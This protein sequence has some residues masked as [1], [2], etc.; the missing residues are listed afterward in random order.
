MAGVGWVDYLWLGNT[1]IGIVRGGQLY[2]V[3]TDHLGRPEVV[4]N[5]ARA[6]VWRANN[7]AFGRDAVTI[8]T[9]GGLHIGFPGQ[10]HDVESGLEHNGM[11]AYDRMRGGYVQTDPIGQ[12][13][14]INTYAY[15]SGN[16]V[17]RIDPW[18]LKDYTACETW[19]ILD[20]AKR[21]MSAPLLQRTANASRNHGAFGKFDFKMNQ[22]ND[23]F[24]APL[25][26]RL[27]APEFGNFIAGYSG[28]IYGGRA[29]LSLVIAGGVLFDATDAM[30]GRGTFDF[31]ADSLKD[32]HNGAAVANMEANGSLAPQCG[33]T[34]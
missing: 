10:Y 30:G 5:S 23:T 13:G 31:D 19:A 29:G 9:L 22:P 14:G 20:D 12:A 34:N 2:G 26:G 4:T 18:G 28:I 27:S 33:C 1:L 8:D 11:R 21:D 25:A 24:A 7:G 17:S 15:A 3:H 16:P 6:V 32:I